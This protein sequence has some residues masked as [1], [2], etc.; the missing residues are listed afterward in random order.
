METL[1]RIGLAPR[2]KRRIASRIDR[3]MQRYRGLKGVHLN[4]RR[5][6]P[7]GKGTRYAVSARLELR[8]YDQ[9]V[10]K[11][12][13]NLLKAI[14]DVLDVGERQLRRRN[15]LIKTRRRSLAATF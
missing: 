8:G 7:R 6:A 4:C 14:V 10:K 1:N 9:I 5:E 12:S 2:L 15:R 3:L 13:G 11:R